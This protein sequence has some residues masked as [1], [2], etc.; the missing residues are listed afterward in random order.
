MI[1]KLPKAK[2]RI[3]WMNVVVLLWVLFAMWMT[4]KGAWSVLQFVFKGFQ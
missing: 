1:T 4:G 2:I 3:Y